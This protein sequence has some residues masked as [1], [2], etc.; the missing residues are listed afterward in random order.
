MV[1]LN[2]I[3]G[4]LSNL[5]LDGHA[6]SCKQHFSCNDLM[7]NMFLE[8]ILGMP[9]KKSLLN[10]DISIEL[11]LVSNKI[12]GLNLRIWWTHQSSSITPLVDTF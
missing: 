8:K 10:F 11:S 6:T 7:D 4:L 2:F 3:R 9:L 1:G 5:M 12:Q